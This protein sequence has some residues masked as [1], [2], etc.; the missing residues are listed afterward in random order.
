MYLKSK[1]VEKIARSHSMPNQMTE[2]ELK[3][4][5]Q[6]IADDVKNQVRSNTR[7]MM[8]I[9]GLLFGFVGMVS[10][11]SLS[12]IANNRNEIQTQTSDMGVLIKTIS[13][14]H[15]ENPWIKSLDEK[16]SPKRGGSS[17]NK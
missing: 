15:P 9:G 12:Q 3:L 8:W 6:F 11:Y 16:Y 4:L 2:K 10:G 1:D 14:E 17:T 5:A 13:G 7:I